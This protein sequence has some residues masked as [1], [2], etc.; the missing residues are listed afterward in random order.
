MDLFRKNALFPLAMAVATASS[1]VFALDDFDLEADKLLLL[2]EIVVTARK[3]EE[4]LQHSPVA[5]SAFDTQ[6]LR[7]LG[8]AN[9]R[10]LSI[11][12]PSLQFTEAGTKAPIIFIRGI[13]QRESVASLDPTVGVYLN[14]IYIP[15]TDS[16]LLDTVDTESV[17][18]L[19]GPQG[20]LFGKNTTG[21]AIVVTSRS[22]NTDV[23][24]GEAS[25]RLGN[26]GRRDAKLLLNIPLAEDTL[27]MRAALASVKRDGYMENIAGDRDFGDEERLAASARLLWTPTRSFSADVFLYG[28]KQNENG[29]GVNCLFVNPNGNLSGLLVYPGQGAGTT[30][31]QTSCN[32]SERAADDRKVAMTDKSAFRLTNE[33]MALT[34]DWD[35]DVVELKSITAYGHQE[36][37]VVEDDQDG[38]PLEAL[39]NGSAT[40]TNYLRD[41]GIDADDEERDQLSQEFNL[42]GTAFD[43][44]LSYTLG[45][46]YS[47]ESM[48]NTPYAQAIGPGTF[49]MIANTNGLA[50]HKVLATQSDIESETVAVFAQGTLDVTDWFQ[51]TA[52]A[53]FT[54]EKRERESRVYNVDLNTLSQRTGSTVTALGLAYGSVNNFNAAYESYLAGDFAIPMELTSTE[55]GDETWNKVT[56]AITASFVNL[57]NYLGWNHLDSM[58][59]YATVSEGFKSGG[60]EPLGTTLKV[61][62]PEELINY[63]I[64]TKIDTFD[65]RLRINAAFYYMDYD[66]IQVRVAEVGTGGV[67]DINLSIDNAGKANIAG[68]ELEVV[69]VP[70]DNLT[71]AAAFNYTDASYDEYV[72]KEVVSG[73]E[74][75][76]DRSD[77]PFAY[78]PETTASFAVNY[79]FITRNAGTWSPRLTVYYRDE[80]F[81]GLDSYAPRYDESTLP[82]YTLLNARL[83]WSFGRDWN[84]AAFVDNVTDKEYYQGGFAVTQ[85]LGA[86]MVSP[87]A[88][89]MYGLEAHYE[90]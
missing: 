5:I 76:T 18:V 3:R 21:G 70:A 72:T 37:I 56:P 86:V 74:I 32:E 19:R 77:E 46:F 30:S 60:L 14:G 75:T 4:S 47:Y 29:L 84:I 22:P 59:I 10:D 6:A 81:V 43:E 67:T 31:F 53:R 65:H 69:A 23:F 12:A 52:G 24:S 27:A 9:I 39:Q 50:T 15:R 2:N 62:E 82:A 71:L 54:Q 35:L 90:F 85:A 20:T 58:L 40:L 57:E 83:N 49:A 33:M 34:L 45:L 88:P 7:E 16:Q 41:G 66:D 17:Q 28:S 51:L 78:T 80:V 44:S 26:F 87:G 13:G 48:D 64:G 38:S 73:V 61:F 68:V 11:A 63:E 36:D 79:D 89:R 55:K 42:I 8:T 25:T 1:P